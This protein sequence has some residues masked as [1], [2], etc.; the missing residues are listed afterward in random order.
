MHEDWERNLITICRAMTFE[1]PL[2]CKFAGRRVDH[3][4]REVPAAT[5]RVTSGGT[6]P[7]H[8]ADELLT[9]ALS[10]TLYVHC[11][12]RHFSGT[13]PA[14]SVVYDPDFVPDESFGKRL[15]VA[16]QSRA[17]WDP[18]WEVCRI[19]DQGDIQARHGDRYRSVPAGQYA[20]AAGPGMETRCGDIVSLQVLAESFHVQ[21]GMYLAFGE[22]LE[23]QYDAV[24]QIRFYFAIQPTGAAGLV[25]RLTRAFNRFSIPFELKCQKYRENYDRIDPVVLY[26][27]RRYADLAQVLVKDCLDDARP[28]LRPHTPLFTLRFDV[29]VGVAEQPPGN[30]SF[31]QDRCDMIA[32]ALFAARRKH[33]VEPSLFLDALRCQFA[34]RNLSYDRPHLNAG[35]SKIFAKPME[36]ESTR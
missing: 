22:T 24:D 1:S 3:E 11:F 5:K 33:A 13:L 27:A 31:G 16:N 20:F 26:I 18:G 30:R 21:P 6:F 14:P 32:A 25:E 29:G 17:G 7:D 2:L 12:A 19:G 9:A 36:M 28:F 15:S 10:Q 8:S 23:D 34:A 35:R 4:S